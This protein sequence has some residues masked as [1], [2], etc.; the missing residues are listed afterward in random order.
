ME[1]DTEVLDQSGDCD[2]GDKGEI[3]YLQGSILH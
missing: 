3:I 1:L 2:G